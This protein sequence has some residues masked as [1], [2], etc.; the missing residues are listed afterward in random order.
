MTDTA[1]KIYMGNNTREMLRDLGVCIFVRFSYGTLVSQL[2]A[3][4]LFAMRCT[5]GDFAAQL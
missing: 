4:H 2:L 3:V 5:H 1:I